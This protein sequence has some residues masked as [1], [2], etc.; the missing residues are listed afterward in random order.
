LSLVSSDRRHFTMKIR[1]I[2]QVKIGK[3]L[4]LS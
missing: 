2:H 3:R 4:S 1:P